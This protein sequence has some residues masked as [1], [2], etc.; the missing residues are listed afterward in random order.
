M[1]AEMLKQLIVDRAAMRWGTFERE[2][3]QTVFRRTLP[4]VQPVD[5]DWKRS[6]TGRWSYFDLGELQHKSARSLAT[7][8]TQ[9]LRYPCPDLEAEA[10]VELVMHGNVTKARDFMQSVLSRRS[11][12]RK[13]FSESL[14]RHISGMLLPNGHDGEIYENKHWSCFGFM[15]RKFI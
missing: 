15:K 9:D 11:Q 12:A 2:D 14:G 5:G 13:S 6:A 10:V 4:D 3:M 7:W 8:I 1:I